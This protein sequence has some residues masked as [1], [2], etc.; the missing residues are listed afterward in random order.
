MRRWLAGLICAAGAWVVPCQAQSADGTAAASPAAASATAASAAELSQ[1]R[2]RRR[3]L[4]ACI[5][6][7]QGRTSPEYADALRRG[8]AQGRVYARMRFTSADAPPEFELLHRPAAREFQFLVEDFVRKLRMPCHTG[9]PVPVQQLF[10]FVM[11]GSHYGFAPGL[12]FG[13]L[14]QFLRT[15]S[16]QAV[17]L[18]TTA[19]ACPFPIK[20]FYLQPERRNGVWVDSTGSDIPSRRP[21]LDALADSELTL[22]GASLSAVYADTASVQVP[23]GRFEL[24]PREG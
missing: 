13:E 1:E 4:T 19:M 12:G 21:L 7:T 6:H 10:L 16:P 14:L 17:V 22:V 15:R 9:A 8:G 24:K 3:R 2:E 11:E 18:D 20:F 5:R 23:C